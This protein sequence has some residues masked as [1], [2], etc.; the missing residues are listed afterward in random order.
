M[1]VTVMDTLAPGIAL[2]SDTVEL[3]NLGLGSLDTTAVIVYIRDNCG[4]NTVVYS[5]LNYSVTD[6]GQNTLT[7]TVKDIH[8]NLTVTNTDIYVVDKL[9][10]SVTAKR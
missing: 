10:R 8:N 6:L 2:L 4:I 5:Q 1:Q 7:V 9:G 3:N